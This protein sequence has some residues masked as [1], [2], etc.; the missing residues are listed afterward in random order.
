MG[1]LVTIPI[2][3]Y[4]EKARWALERAGVPYREERHVQGVHILASRLA[5]RPL[6]HDVEGLAD[7]DSLLA[8]LRGMIGLPAL[9]RTISATRKA[10]QPISL[11]A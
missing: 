4:C 6:A 1:R 10:A 5:G 11:G 3:H 9:F 7:G 2:S 8:K